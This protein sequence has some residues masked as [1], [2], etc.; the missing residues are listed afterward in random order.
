MLLRQ[1][2]CFIYMDPWVS[3]FQKPDLRDK[4]N[5]VVEFQGGPFWVA[6][7][8]LL[9][10]SHMDGGERGSLG[11]CLIRALILFMRTPPS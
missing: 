9:L 6:D 3:W 7:G 5:S 1:P 4:G 10:W 11:S 8:R 2:G